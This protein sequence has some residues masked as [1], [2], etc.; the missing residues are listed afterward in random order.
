MQVLLFIAHHW[1]DIL[2]VI[3]LIVSIMTGLTKWTAKYGPI[4]EK[5]SLR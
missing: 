4:F 1:H 5:M 3:L 2:V